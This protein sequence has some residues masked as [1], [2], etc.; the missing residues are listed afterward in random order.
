MADTE[1]T[2]E[3]IAVALIELYLDGMVEFNEEGDV[4][5][6]TEKGGQV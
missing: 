6:L 3:E 4:V 5:R 1:V 2:E